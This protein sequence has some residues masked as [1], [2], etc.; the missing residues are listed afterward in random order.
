MNV[1]VKLDGS[2][3]GTPVPSQPVLLDQKSCFYQPRVLGAVRRVGGGGGA[4]RQRN[5][6]GTRAEARNHRV[7]EGRL[8]RPARRDAEDAD[9]VARVVA[10]EAGCQS[11]SAAGGI[12]GSVQLREQPSRLSAERTS[13]RS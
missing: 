10:G 11:R 7:V 9:A 1:F 3:P 4:Q 2:F 12:H 6:R 8:A 13:G 5:G